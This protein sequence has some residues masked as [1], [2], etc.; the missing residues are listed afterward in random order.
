[1]RE[2]LTIPHSRS[3]LLV[4][5]VQRQ[6][7]EGFMRKLG[8]LLLQITICFYGNVASADFRLQHAAPEDSTA[9]LPV[10]PV[11][12]ERVPKRQSQV[13][14]RTCKKPTELV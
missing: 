4:T 2:E 13:T 10:S 11:P 8:T 3:R 5:R 9:F 6:M 14:V 12:D 1:M 7:N